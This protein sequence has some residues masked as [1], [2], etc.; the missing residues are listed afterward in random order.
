MSGEELKHSDGR[1]SYD[2]AVIAISSAGSVLSLETAEKLRGSMFEY[3]KCTVDVF[4]FEK[5]KPDGAAAESFSNVGELVARIFGKYDALIF[6]CACGIAVRAIAPHIRSKVTDP[7][8]I[9]LD[10]CGKFAIPLLSGHIGGA[11]ALARRVAELI[12]AV[13]VITTATDNRGKFSPDLFAKANDL[14]LDDLDAAKE[15][16]AAVLRGESIDLQSQFPMINVPRDIFRYDHSTAGID[17][18]QRNVPHIEGGIPAV[19]LSLTARNIF[20]GIGCKRGVPADTIERT[21][22]TGLES[23]GY[24][25]RQV[26]GIGTID[27][28]KDEK[29][30]LEFADR[31]NLPISFFSAEE[32]MN[33][34]ER[35]CKFSSSEFVLKVT[36]A[37]N[38]CE[39]AAVL[40][41]GG[42]KLL[43]IRGYR[44]WDREC[45]TLAAAAMDIIIDFEKEQS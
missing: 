32:L 34:P 36:G 30:L 29:G 26:R 19:C 40:A 7:A 37:D 23:S 15:V 2:I 6:V 38:V 25:L 39:R 21:V 5:N 31:H 42:G 45:V 44:H 10:D 16:A 41:S 28:K 4:C 12:G 33:A 13:P 1:H 35:G 27:I 9:V 43:L 17:I 22:L 3:C 20:I 11:N 8:V 14:F 24:A 18:S